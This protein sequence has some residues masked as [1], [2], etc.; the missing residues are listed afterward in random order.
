M[1]AAKET[2][3]GGGEESLRPS[4]GLTSMRGEED[5]RREEELRVTVQF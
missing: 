1:K 2:G 3:R 5:G 4:V